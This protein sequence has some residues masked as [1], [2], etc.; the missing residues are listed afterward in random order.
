MA[1]R[2]PMEKQNQALRANLGTVLPSTS[3]QIGGRPRIYHQVSDIQLPLA[4]HQVQ[5]MC[6]WN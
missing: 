4:V 3:E 6:I 1:P 2:G 5:D